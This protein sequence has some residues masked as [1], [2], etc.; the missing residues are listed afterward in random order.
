MSNYSTEMRL[1]YSVPA[2]PVCG[3]DRCLRASHPAQR[4]DLEAAY[5]A[6]GIADDGKFDAEAVRLGRS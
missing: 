2:R 1:W 5:E 6:H 4:G 3:S